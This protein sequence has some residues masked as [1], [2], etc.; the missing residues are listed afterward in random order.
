[1]RISVVP[2]LAIGCACLSLSACKVADEPSANGETEQA[3]DGAINA[4]IAAQDG[5]LVLP[6]VRGNPAAVY[7]TLSYAGESGQSLVGASVDGAKMTQMHETTMKDGKMSM[8]ETGPLELV[9]GEDV[10]FEPGGKHLMAMELTDTLKPGDKASVT[11]R[12]S[13]GE[14]HRFDADVL[15]AGD[16]R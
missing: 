3:Q 12:F 4:F 9:A 13:N 10:V 8:A 1:M 15:A 14:E 2:I 11:L 7:F 6:A 16:R 5:R